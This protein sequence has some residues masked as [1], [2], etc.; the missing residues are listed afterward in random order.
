M[1]AT[2]GERGVIS[3]WTRAGNEGWIYV[4]L[5]KGAR[6]LRVTKQN[7]RSVLCLTFFLLR[8]R[9]IIS[10]L[11]VITVG[12]QE[13]GN[14]VSNSSTL[15]GTG[16]TT[17]KKKYLMEYWSPRLFDAILMYIGL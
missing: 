7:R 13:W 17:M 15:L 5:T 9:P 3:L 2:R 12:H 6:V 11:L 10:R 1:D 4:E 8:P 14:L 16:P